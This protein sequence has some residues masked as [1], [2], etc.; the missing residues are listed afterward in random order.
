VKLEH[1]ILKKI[2]KEELYKVLKESLFLPGEEKEKEEAIKSLMN[3]FGLSRNQAIASIEK[4][5]KEF[6]KDPGYAMQHKE[7]SSKVRETQSDIEYFNKTAKL[8]EQEFRSR[9]NPNVTSTIKG[10]KLP[11]INIEEATQLAYEFLD[12]NNKDQVEQ[13]VFNGYHEEIF[14]RYDSNEQ[15][16]EIAPELAKLYKDA[17]KG[18]WL[19]DMK[20]PSKIKE[21]ESKVSKIKK[22]IDDEVFQ[23]LIYAASLG[24]EKKREQEEREQKRKEEEERKRREEEQRKET[25]KRNAQKRKNEES[26]MLQIAGVKTMEEFDKLSPEK[27]MN[28]QREAYEMNNFR[29][30]G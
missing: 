10:K 22:Q 20:T 26:L 6:M 9:S 3:T 16:Q 4:S 5:G 7:L 24:I 13:K 14:S 12:K 27:Q 19:R 21:L 23:K 29:R 18:V 1:K 2:I 25:E 17:E 8:G 15:L 11:K 28:A 30:I